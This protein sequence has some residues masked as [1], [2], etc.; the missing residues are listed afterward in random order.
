MAL[1]VRGRRWSECALIALAL[2]AGC[3]SPPFTTIAPSRGSGGINAL[4]QRGKPYVVMI[5]FDG[6]RADYLDRHATPNLHRVIANGVRVDALIP[7][8]PSK[9]FPNHYTIA[10]GLYPE[11]HGIVANAF[12]DPQRRD[13]YTASTAK[14]AQDG[15]WYRGEPIWVTA[16]RQGMVAGAF[17]WPGSEAAIQGV[18]PT[19]WKAYEQTTPDTARVD[20]VLAWLRL[21][22]DRRP[23]LIALY[24]GDVDVVAHRVGPDA[25]EIIPAVAV[26]D[27]AIGRLLDGLAALDVRDSVYLLL[28]SDHGLAAYTPSE[29]VAIDRLVDTNVVRVADVGPVAN[30]HVPG[31]V[32]ASRHL[33]DSINKILEHGRAYLRADVPARLHYSVDPRIGDVVIIMDEPYVLGYAAKVPKP[34]THGQHGWDPASPSMH[35]IF[36]VQGPGIPRGVRIPAFDNVDIYPFLTELLGLRAAQPID[37]AAGRLRALAL[38]GTAAP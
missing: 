5:S 29:Y 9:T 22:P 28:V 1:A 8:F 34:G 10:T 13:T 26:V 21:A 16:E 35:G 6:F 36:I 19:H 15:R 11:H 18:R 30:L 23:H 27:Q 4:E 17:I 32:D 12:Y 7:A 33:R 2:V 20:S 38:R 37:G 14:D 24:M 31:G 3:G 25:P